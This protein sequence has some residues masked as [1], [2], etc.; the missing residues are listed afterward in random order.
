MANALGAGEIAAVDLLPQ[1][2]KLAQQLGATQV[3]NAAG[4]A[5]GEFLKAGRLG[6]WADVVFECSGAQTTVQQSI[7][8]AARGGRVVWVGMGSDTVEIPLIKGLVKELAFY[9]VFRYVNSYP[10][11]I[12]L[13]ER[14]RIDPDPLVSHRFE[15]PAVQEALEFCRTHRGESIKTVV[16]FPEK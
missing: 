1:R 5:A 10:P 11:V 2:L 12:S 4:E 8:V 3:V 16:N 7:E 15:F 6:D 9:G 13:L 14:G